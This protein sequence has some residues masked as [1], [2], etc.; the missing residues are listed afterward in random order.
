MRLFLLCLFLL[1]GFAP[2][3]DAFSRAY[4]PVGDYVRASPLVVVADIATQA[5]TPF[6]TIVTVREVLKSESVA[7]AV[8]VAAGDK[9]ILPL[10]MTRWVVPNT[11]QNA[12]VV[13]APNWKN[14]P[15][16]QGLLVSEVYQTPAQIE[17]VR[18]FIEI[19]RLPT[20][21]A[22]LL[23]LQAS[24]GQNNKWLDQQLLADL[25]RMRNRDN[26]DIALESYARLGAENRARIIELLGT[27][28]DARALPLLIGALDAPDA[29]IWRRALDQLIYHF[30]DANGVNE[31]LRALLSNTEKRSFVL[32]YLSRRDPSVPTRLSQIEPTTGMR[33]Q[34]LL[35][36]GDSKA[37][38]TAF[39]AVID[40]DAGSKYGFSTMS[41]ARELI[42]LVQ[43]ETDKSRLR[44]ALLTRLQA[45]SNYL[46]I[47]EIIQ[48]LRQLPAP[49]NV[50][51][52]LSKLSPPPETNPPSLSA[53]MWHKP[54]R[55][56]TFALL[57]LGADARKRGTAHVIASLRARPEISD[58]AATVAVCELAWLADDATWKSAAQIAPAVARQI[59]QLQPLRDAAQS[60]N[61]A[62]SLAMLLPDTDN[63]W[64]N[65]SDGW[66][67]ARLGELRD[68]VAVAPLLAELKRAPY[69]GRDQDFRLALLQIG[70][71]SAQR[72]AL[73]LL[74]YPEPSQRALGMDVLREL[75]DYDVRPL[76]LKILEGDDV[77]DKTH[78]IFLLG[79]I[80]TPQDLPALEKLAD[81]WTT[82]LVYQRRAVDAITGIRERYP[83]GK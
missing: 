17:A 44:R 47:P 26:F 51:I 80:G 38:I 24:A 13:M 65:R 78:A 22:R 28:G 76:L 54:A 45:S 20:E 55:E 77:S 6:A 31:A 12:V 66:S 46:S 61:E 69:A 49:A 29:K 73:E 4:R 56:T 32:D 75:P 37:A 35:K 52:L 10:G 83:Q 74:S 41:A 16:D 5:A 34:K 71:I 79:Y 3:A 57:E 14:Q 53:Y 30:P 62:Q 50:E 67:I 18:A 63:R 19:D 68:S 39:F 21:R 2:R 64:Q 11:A 72:G 43:N 59:A 27:I 7:E 1:I 70:G 82:D 8:P 36:D 60:K 9:I 48:L 15:S 58:E 25:G 33:A 40:E 42:P 81:F 23:A